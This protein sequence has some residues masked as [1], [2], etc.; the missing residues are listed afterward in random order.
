MLNPINAAKVTMVTCILHNLLSTRRP[1]QYL[2]VTSDQPAPVHPNLDWQDDN[3]LAS[4]QT[5]QG[6]TY[7]KAG[8]AV[9]DHLRDYYNSELGAVEWQDAAVLK[10]VSNF[11]YKKYV[12]NQNDIA[13]CLEMFFKYA[14]KSQV[15]HQIQM[16][17]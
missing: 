7:R 9:R 1:K 14:N 6:S 5:Q 8:Q 17:L 16:S 12:P 13:N 4:L 15:P 3:T 2:G 10:H 11:K